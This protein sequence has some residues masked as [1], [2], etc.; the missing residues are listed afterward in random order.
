MEVLAKA[1]ALD[2]LG[3]VSGYARPMLV[4][5]VD[6]FVAYCAAC[7]EQRESGQGGLFGDADDRVDAAPYM[8][9]LVKETNVNPL[10]VLGWEQEVIGFYLSD[11]PLGGMVNDLKGLVNYKPLSEIETFAE[12]G[13]GNA[14]VAGIVL[15]VREVK[16]KKGDRMGIISLSDPSGQGEVVVFPEAYGQLYDVLHGKEALIFGVQVKQDGERIRVSSEDVKLLKTVI[17]TREQVIIKVPD[18]ALL[19]KVQALLEHAG[20]GNTRVTLKM[21]TLQGEAVVKLP[22]G[23][24]YGPMLVAGLKQL[25]IEG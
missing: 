4:H 5:N 25:G 11:H 6:V 15:G 1:G 8:H 3:K 2:A 24:A 7:A 17:G 22:R 12:R 18:G 19:P 23:V 21:P 14:R 20:A 9:S 10:E 16:T 13:G